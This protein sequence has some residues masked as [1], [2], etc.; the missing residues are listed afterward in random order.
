MN[1]RDFLVAGMW[2]VATPRLVWAQ[3]ARL[4]RLGYLASGTEA[5]SAL[6]RSAVLEGLAALGYLQ[7]RDFI[8]DAR[9][10]DSRFERLDK[11]A[12]ELVKSRVEIILTQTTPATSAARRATSVIPIISITSGDLLGAKLVASLGRPGGNVTGLSFLGTELAVK[13]MELIKRVVPGAKR[14][15]LVASRSFAPESLFYQEMEKAA[16]SMGLDVQFVETSVPP[17]YRAVFAILA[18]DRV[19]AV[20]I[21]AGNLNHAN[22]PEIVER[23]RSDR[24]PAI[25]PAAEA[26]NAGGLMSYGIDRAKFYRNAANYVDRILR[27]AKPAEL[28]VEQPTQFE[29]VVS[30]Q[31]ARAIGLELSDA[32]LMR[33]DRVIE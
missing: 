18:R 26:V 28:P 31:A 25:Y 19:D 32:F 4:H 23:A 5:T 3:A 16:P 14:V 20:V 15:A 21:A 27:G 12:A 13:Q 6:T 22:W 1:R 24:I 29:L 10:A 2:M 7:G 11:L 8:L 9:Y 30:R 17:D 33:A